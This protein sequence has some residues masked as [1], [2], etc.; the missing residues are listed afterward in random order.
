[1]KKRYHNLPAAQPRQVG[2]AAVRQ[3][4]R[5][6]R[7]MQREFEAHSIDWD[8]SEGLQQRL[9]GLGQQDYITW[10]GH[11]TYLLRIAGRTL[12]IDPFFSERASPLSFLGPKRIVAPALSI[13]QLP[14][15]DYVLIT[16]NHYDHLD[17]ASIIALEKRFS[18]R[19][20]VPEGLQKTLKKWRIKNTHEL[21][22]YANYQSDELL[23]T[24]LPAYHYSRRRLFDMNLSWWCSFA[25]SSAKIKLF[26]SGDTGYGEG[27]KQIGKQFQQFDYAMIGIGAYRPANMMRGVHINPEEATQIAIDIHANVM[28]PMHWGT[29]PLTPEPFAEPIQ[30]LQDHLTKI[31]NP[32]ALA[33]TKI[34]DIININAS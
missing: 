14:K 23:I 22:W 10:L 9:H 13:D 12:L 21:A 28:L 17:K 33:L 3:L 11:A 1:M 4:I 5:E 8:N 20:I 2:W 15:I 26:H 19:M 29:I 18:P 16:H 32:P 25:I 34:G 31:A 7:L 6:T 30:W 27:F 24:A